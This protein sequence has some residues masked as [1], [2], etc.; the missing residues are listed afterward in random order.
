MPLDLKQRLLG[1]KSFFLAYIIATLLYATFGYIWVFHPE[2][3][4]FLEGLPLRIDFVAYLICT[5]PVAISGFVHGYRKAAE[6]PDATPRSRLDS[7][8]YYLQLYSLVCLT[9]GPFFW[10]NIIVVYWQIGIPGLNLAAQM[11]I[12][13]IF[14]YFLTLSSYRF[15]TLIYVIMG[16]YFLLYVRK[17]SQIFWVY[18]FFLYIGS[19]LAIGI[20][21]GLNIYPT[22]LFSEPILVYALSALGMFVIVLGLYLFV[23]HYKEKEYN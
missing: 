4:A 9:F 19:S 7:G 10:D 14:V 11:E 22:T 13:F 23:R 1:V 8:F 15:F 2:V 6:S 3:V 16:T 5:I 20:A 12:Q 18:L 17:R 21:F